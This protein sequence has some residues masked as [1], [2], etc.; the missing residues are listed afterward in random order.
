MH[1]LP[2]IPAINPSLPLSNRRGLC[3]I[4]H[5]AKITKLGNCAILEQKAQTGLVYDV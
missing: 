5:T 3:K 1:P 2:A 4:A